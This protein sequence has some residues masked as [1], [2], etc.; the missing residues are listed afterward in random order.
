MELVKCVTVSPVRQP[1]TDLQTEKKLTFDL[2]LQVL[3]RARVW[4]PERCA[5]AGEPGVGI[6]KR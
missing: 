4:Q 6:D 1:R 2:F 3:H 5:P